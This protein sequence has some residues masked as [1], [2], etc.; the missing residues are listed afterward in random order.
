MQ[1]YTVTKDTDIEDYVTE[2]TT[3]HD[4]TVLY[5]FSKEL[6]AYLETI[7]AFSPYYLQYD[8]RTA[9]VMDNF[10][11]ATLQAYAHIS[12]KDLHQYMI[13]RLTTWN[14]EFPPPEDGKA[15]VQEVEMEDAQVGDG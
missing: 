10:Y 12:Y 4:G 7:V 15:P 11:T 8:T 2:L 13:R 1:H 9:G 3:L 6:L 14:E 5:S